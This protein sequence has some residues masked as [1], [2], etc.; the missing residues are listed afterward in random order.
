MTFSFHCRSPEPSHTEGSPET[1]TELDDIFSDSIEHSAV[2]LSEPPIEAE[3]FVD[4]CKLLGLAPVL[5]LLIAVVAE[6]MA[7]AAAAECHG[8]AAAAAV[9]TGVAAAAIADRGLGAEIP[10]SQEV[11]GARPPRML[12]VLG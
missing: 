8:V 4:P 6:D 11:W 3:T 7:G 9:P 2:V 10:G 12:L 1:Q 5:K